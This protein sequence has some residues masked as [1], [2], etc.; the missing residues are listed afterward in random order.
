MPPKANPNAKFVR[1]H[2]SPPDESK[3]YQCMLCERV[4]SPT[5]GNIVRHIAETCPRAGKKQEGGAVH[6]SREV[7]DIGALLQQGRKRSRQ[8]VMSPLMKWHVL[9]STPFTRMDHPLLREHYSMS[10]DPRM[11]HITSA[12]YKRALKA[13][14]ARER[15]RFEEEWR[16]VQT[17]SISTDTWTCHG[18][19]IMVVLCHYH[20]NCDLGLGLLALEKLHG[21]KTA[22]RQADIIKHHL[23]DRKPS[24]IVSD[25]E[26][27]MRRLAKILDV[28]RIG[29]AAHLLALAVED[30]LAEMAGA[31][32]AIREIAR[33][34]RGPQAWARL[35]ESCAKLG[36]APLRPPMPNVTRWNSTWRAAAAIMKLQ[37]AMRDVAEQ[38]DTIDI[39]MATF[40][41]IAYIAKAFAAAEE[42]TRTASLANLT[43]ADAMQWVTV[44]ERKLEV[45]LDVDD[46][47]STEGS[48]EAPDAEWE[49]G[50]DAGSAS[51][52]DAEAEEANIKATTTLEACAATLRS[53]MQRRFAP[54]L[55]LYRTAA[56]TTPAG[57]AALLGR[58]R[59]DAAYEAL[60][61]QILRSLEKATAKTKAGAE[62]VDQRSASVAERETARRTEAARWLD[63]ELR[64]VPMS[65]ARY[66][67]MER[68]TKYPAVYAAAAPYLAPLASV[69]AERCFSALGLVWSSKRAHLAHDILYQS[70]T[71]RLALR[72]FPDLLFAEEGP[73]AKVAAVAGDVVEL[74]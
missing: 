33:F 50:S 74:S 34:F 5:L 19:N 30:A 51:S 41:A 49:S 11:M 37:A 38:H 24:F 71:V 54:F 15:D 26:A 56:Y 67:T 60:R 59:S 58:T 66:W 12:E 47:T 39:P 46:G 64:T 42:A 40:R 14:S 23:K 57:I 4:W 53:A 21:D 27:T 25:N 52:D 9:F 68:R 16:S 36:I 28:P 44:L 22:Q 43:V 70:L 6:P 32:A 69:E 35:R 3:P 48:E 18:T 62:A 1:K 13:T 7:G 10:D 55:E 17:F 45:A 20:I 8:E 65:A 2:P 72:R 73:Q 61:A 63:E 31:K 29:C